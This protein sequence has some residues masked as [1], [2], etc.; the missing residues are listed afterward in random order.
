MPD[1]GPTDS[2]KDHLPMADNIFV[3]MKTHKEEE[4]NDGTRKI[5]AF[6]ST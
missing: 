5:V 2:I 4:Q 6:D 1:A 3:E